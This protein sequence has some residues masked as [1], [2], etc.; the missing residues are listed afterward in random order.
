MRS[1]AEAR[2]LAKAVLPQVALAD[3]VA[4]D[5]RRLQASRAGVA[6][7]DPLRLLA[8][9]RAAAGLSFLVHG[10][11]TS[12]RIVLRHGAQEIEIALPADPA[13]VTAALEAGGLS[14]GAVHMDHERAGSVEL[15]SGFAE[16][17]APPAEPL[18]VVAARA[19]D[20]RGLPILVRTDITLPGPETSENA[21]THEIVGFFENRHAVV[22]TPG[23]PVR[24]TISDTRTGSEIVFEAR[25]LDRDFA[26]VD[27]R[28][29]GIRLGNQSLAAKIIKHGVLSQVVV[30]VSENAAEQIRDLPGA[31]VHLSFPLARQS[32]FRFLLARDDTI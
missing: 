9:R 22:L 3:G 10:T 17:S 19:H 12:G 2:Y 5:M 7:D 26:T 18:S 8:T 16:F 30:G 15:F 6:R 25:L 28:E 4:T 24:G 1:E 20:E 27:T 29:L 32:L 13:R 14:V 11:A 31:V 21:D 23:Q